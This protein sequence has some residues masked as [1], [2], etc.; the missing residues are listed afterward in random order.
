[1]RH[2]IV[3]GIGRSGTST[4]AR[5]LHQRLG[6]CMGHEFLNAT[7][8]KKTRNPLGFWE[9]QRGAMTGV[10]KLLA[11]GRVTPEKWVQ[12][13]DR[14]HDHHGC[15]SRLRGYKHPR[16]ANIE[17]AEIWRALNPLLVIKTWRPRELVLQSMIIA[18][19]QKVAECLKRYEFRERNMEEHLK[20][21]RT[22]TIRFERRLSDDEVCEI[23]R[24]QIER[25]TNG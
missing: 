3:V 8:L 25:L 24:P 12:H 6:V 16:L 5:I 7:G 22:F 4:T 13:L 18:N 1:M 15:K 17:S 10:T 19:P 20:G 2:V 23:L 14:A 21:V 11:K 9:E